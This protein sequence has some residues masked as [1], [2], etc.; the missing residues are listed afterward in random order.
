MR[1]FLIL[2]VLV[3]LVGCASR[4]AVPS[5]SLTAA[6]PPGAEVSQ[7]TPNRQQVL[8]LLKKRVPSKLVS[9]HMATTSKLLRDFTSLYKQMIDAKAITCQWSESCVCW[10]HCKPTGQ[11]DDLQVEHEEQGEVAGSMFI[12]VGW[13]QVTEVTGISSTGTSSA[14]A[15]Y[16]V[17]YTPNRG[18]SLLKEFPEVF[19]VDNTKSESHRAYLRK[20]DDGWRIESLQ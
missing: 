20:Y 3:I 18:P 17:S 12:P 7:N 1:Y 8:D 13:K 6:Q 11:W 10:V 19:D 14:V 9:G 5:G 15:E 16:L 2:I 4:E